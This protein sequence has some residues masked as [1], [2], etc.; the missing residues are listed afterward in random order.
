MTR[1]CIRHPVCLRAVHP[2][3]VRSSLCRA[4]CVSLPVCLPALSVTHPWHLGVLGRVAA[5]RARLPACS[6]ATLCAVCAR[7]VARA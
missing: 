7:V 3:C 2:A 4:S 6:H 1:A 5:F